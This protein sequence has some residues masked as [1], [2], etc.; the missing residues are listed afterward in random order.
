MPLVHTKPVEEAT[1][2]APVSRT[3]EQLVQDS[4]DGNQEAWSEL[5]DKSKNLIFS[6]P[7]KFG[8]SRDEAAD[9]FQDVCLSCS[10]S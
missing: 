4:L 1:S 5:I 9:I 7:I 10:P 2:R 8:F 3:D 6:V